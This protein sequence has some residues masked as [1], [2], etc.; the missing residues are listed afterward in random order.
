MARLAG[1]S[2]QITP[3]KHCGHQGDVKAP[4]FKVERRMNYREQ[5]E[6]GSEFYSRSPLTMV[7]CIVC[8]KCGEVHEATVLMG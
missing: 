3:C 8:L 6:P 7:E 5:G 1:I 4:N 2:S